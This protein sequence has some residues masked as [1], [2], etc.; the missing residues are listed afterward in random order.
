MK[1]VLSGGGTAGPA[2]ADVLLT[3]GH[4]VVFAQGNADGVE[5]PWQPA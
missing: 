5:R 2:L 3:R 4:E 1:V